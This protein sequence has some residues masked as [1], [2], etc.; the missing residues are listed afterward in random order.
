VVVAD[1]A[2]WIWKVV[3][4]RWANAVEVLDFYHA[5]EHLWNLGQALWGEE[6]A[7]GWVERR[8]HQLRH[9]QEQTVLAEVLRLKQRP[10]EVG[11]LI[12]KEQNYFVQQAKRMK[13]QAIARQGWPIGS[14]PVE[15]A[16]RDRQGRCK[17]P[18]QFWT[19]RGLR[20][21][22][23][24]EEARRNGHWDELSFAT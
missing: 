4:D 9:G 11:A 6:Q 24:L 10:G 16:C 1:G 14:G 19:E 23:A 2:P 17:R 21:L 15:S 8:L 13:Y 5:S 12:E 18:G 3:A 20:H 22:C 7:A